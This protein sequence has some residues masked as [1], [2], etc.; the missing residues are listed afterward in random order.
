[1]AALP[2]QTHI[3]QASTFS[4]GYRKR[5]M[6]LGDGYSMRVQDGINAVMWTGTFVF[7][8]LTLAELSI[9]MSFLDGIGSW[10]TFDYTPP[11][12]PASVKWA[13]SDQGPAITNKGLHYD[14]SFSARQEYDLA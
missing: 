11:G 12:A 14:V 10:G 3:S 4:K 6:R 2:L 8:N 9:L 7:P 5:E 1:M 13:V